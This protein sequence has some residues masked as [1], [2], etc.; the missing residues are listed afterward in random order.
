MTVLKEEAKKAGVELNIQLVD[1]SAV[2]KIYL[3]K[4]HEIAY[5]GWS[6][7]S[8][9]QFWESYH[10]KNANKPQTNNISNTSD[11]KIDQLIDLYDVTFDEKKKISLSHQI[12]QLIHDRGSFIP[13]YSNEFYREG[14]WRYWRLPKIPGTK[15]AMTSFDISDSNGGLFWFD[16]DK[17]EETKKAKK[18]NKSLP[19]IVLKDKTYLK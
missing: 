6:T 8:I 7:G 5:M 13:G 2:F 16:K 17:F 4:K 11:P 19:V 12:Q 9:P 10:S 1:P 3:E 18:E 14:Y 15:T